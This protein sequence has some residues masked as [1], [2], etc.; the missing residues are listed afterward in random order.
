[1]V[2]IQVGPTLF[3]VDCLRVGHPKSMF[4]E[5]QTLKVMLDA[6][7]TGES[8]EKVIEIGL[9]LTCTESLL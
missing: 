9:P 5:R 3:I 1:M 8:Y 7:K 6:T 4:Q 2:A